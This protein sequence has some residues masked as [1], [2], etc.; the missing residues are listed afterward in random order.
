MF[1]LLPGTRDAVVNKTYNLSRDKHQ[2]NNY[3]H[4]NLIEIETNAMK[5]KVM[6]RS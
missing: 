2:I 3:T 1:K 4:E 6:N 5:D